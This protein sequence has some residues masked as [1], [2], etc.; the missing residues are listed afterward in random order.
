MINIPSATEV[1]A[2]GIE[3]GEMNRLLL[4]KIEEITL[5]LIEINNEN[6]KL[7]QLVAKQQQEL[8]ELQHTINT[9]KK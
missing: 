6:S 2:N 7:K 4:E 1:E 5:Y 8:I 9:T 3:L